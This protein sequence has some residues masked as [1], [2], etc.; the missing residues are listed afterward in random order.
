MRARGI[1]PIHSLCV[2]LC[3]KIARC[4]RNSGDGVID[5]NEF[6]HGSFEDCEIAKGQLCPLGQGRVPRSTVYSGQVLDIPESV[7]PDYLY[8]SA[9]YLGFLI[10]IGYYFIR[11]QARKRY[12]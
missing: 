10:V 6:K 12:G 9:G 5:F 4:S 11:H 2:S 8:I 7:L 1:E 3:L